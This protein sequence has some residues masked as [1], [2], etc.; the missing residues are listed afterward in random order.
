VTI[1]YAF[2]EFVCTYVLNMRVS[3]TA[4]RLT[5]YGAVNKPPMGCEAQLAYLRQLLGVLGDF[6]QQRSPD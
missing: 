6:D 3:L 2:E 4:N 5:V 1:F